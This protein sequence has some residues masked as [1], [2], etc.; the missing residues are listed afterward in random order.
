MSKVMTV[1]DL[2]GV[3]LFDNDATLAIASTCKTDL[4]GCYLNPGRVGDLEEYRAELNAVKEGGALILQFTATWCARCKILKGEID[5]ELR[6]H[7]HT[8]VIRWVVADYDEADELR[9]HFDIDGKMPCIVVVQPSE[10]GGERRLLKAFG[11]NA[12][13]SLVREALRELD[14][15]IDANEPILQENRRRFVL[16]PIK[17]PGI[18][19][20]YKKAEASFWTAEEIDLAQDLS[21]WNSLTEDERHFLSHVLAFFAASDGIVNENLVER[22]ASEVQLAEARCFYGFQI[23]MENIHSE[24]YSLLIDTFIK[25]ESMRAHLFDAIDTVPCVAKKANWAL[26]WIRNSRRFAERVIAFAVVEGIF[27]SGSFCAIF[28]MKKRGLMPGLCF[29]NELISRDE[30]LHCEFACLLYSMLE[31]RLT[32]DMVHEIIT[33]AVEHE[34]EFVCEALPVDLIGMNSTT[35]AQ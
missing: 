19:E 23:A 28:W 33:D 30:G 7:V 34:K 15:D 26:K 12:Q 20:Y 18:W 21:D 16:F 22:F 11:Q 5:E 6:K 3:V 24:T 35:M 17:Y 31:H 29:S 4:S 32:D 25:D 10:F 2:E 9:D 1:V 27:F 14:P 13:V 8:P